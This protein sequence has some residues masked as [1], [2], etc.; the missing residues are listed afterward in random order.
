MSTP[1]TCPSCGQRAV[2]RNTRYGARD[3]CDP[4]GL[5]SWDGKPLVSEE[6]HKARQHCHEAFDR[7]WKTAEEAYDLDTTPG[8]RG[9]EKLVKKIRRAARGRA[10][11]Y[12]AFKTGLPEPE[13]H[14][15]T[16][17]DI[18]KLRLIY[19][20]ARDCPGPAEVRRWW[21][22]TKEPA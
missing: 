7:L 21:Y 19:R 5:W 8:S 15:A 3:A 14:M 10:Y 9:H 18:E 4:C 13:C 20:A 6:V 11:R 1:P 22:E 17:T 16:Q 12:I 2:R